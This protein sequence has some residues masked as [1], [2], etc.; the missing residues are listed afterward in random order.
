MT[1]KIT[2]ALISVFN[3]NGIE[4]I[5]HTLHQLGVQIISTGG[6]HDF[7]QKMGIPV[8]SVDSITSF[9]EILGGRVKTLHPAVFGGILARR[10]NEND[11]LQIEGHKIPLIDCVIVDLYPFEDT[12]KSTNE[13][14]KIIEKIDIGGIA[15][16]RAA[17]KNFKDTIIVP[18]RRYY[19]EFLELLNNKQGI[20]DEADRKKFATYA[21]AVSSHYDTMIFKYFNES[22]HL[23]YFKE[24]FIEHQSLRYGENPHQKAWWYGNFESHFEKL[25]GKEISYNNL[26]DIDAAVQLISDF[27]EPTFAIIKHNNACGV[28]SRSTIYDAYATALSSD[29]I[30][31][32]GGILVANRKIDFSTAQE[33]HKLF[34]EVIIAP[35]YDEEALSILKTKPNRIILVN[36]IQQLPKFTFK[37]ILNGIVKQERDAKVETK[38]DLKVV[39][40]KS[41]STQEIEDLLFANKIVKH[42]KS[43]AIVIA[44]N[45]Q[46]L[47]GGTGQTSRVD[48]VRHAIEKAHHFKF[49]TKGAVLA[50]DAFFPFPDSIELAHSAGISAVIQPGGS[51]KDKEV[52]DACNQYS[53][54]MVFTSFRHF[55]H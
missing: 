52:I 12:V 20:T 37:N 45:K 25:N 7:I 2:S 33:I 5:V 18:D 17:A 4:P 8:T 9:P 11:L 22:F 36:K 15:L 46:L 32:F 44:K 28:A 51:I 39:T 16:I 23:P 3:K 40:D 27:D 6:T 38:E 21:F 50:S 42:N 29:P 43:N 35:A 31:A 13:E 48:A 54:S 10:N 19:D 1:K 53:I 34:F 14:S 26:L 47:G 24:S 41:P 55:K 49:D 30:S